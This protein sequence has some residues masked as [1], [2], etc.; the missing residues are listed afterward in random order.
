MSKDAWDL[1]S[2]SL[3]YSINN[4]T[5]WTAFG[6][7]TNTGVLQTLAQRYQI[8]ARQKDRAGNVSDESNVVDFTWDRGTLISHV[9]STSANGVYTHVVGRNQIDITVYFRKDLRIGTGTTPRI[10]INAQRGGNNIDLT[11]PT[12][13]IPGGA[14]NSLTFTYNVQNGDARALPT[15]LDIT[16]ISGITAWD[17]NAVNNGVNVSSLITLPTGTPRLDKQIT[18]ETGNLTRNTITFAADSGTEA[19]ANYHGIRSDDGSYWTT[20]DITFNRSINKGSPTGNIIIQQIAGTGN[21][22]YRL[23]A[24]ITEAQ[25]TRFKSNA[26]TSGIIDNYYIKGTNGYIDGTGS[27]TS[28]KYVLQYNYDTISGV[29]SGSPFAGNTAIPAGDITRFRDAEKIEINVNAS[30]VTVDGS[31]LKIRLTGSNAPQVPGATYTVALPDGLV[32]D[33]L[34]NIYA[35]GNENVVLRG[36]AKPFVRINKTQDTITVNANPS[37]TQPRLVAAQPFLAYAR[38]DCRTPGSTITYNQS[39][40]RT[41]VP[42]RL[43]GTTGDNNNWRYD[44]VTPNANDN[45]TPD[46][47]RPGSATGTNYTNS[48]QVTLGNNA[49]GSIPDITDVQ[50][51]QWWV[52]ARAG[53][54]TTYSLETEEMAYRTVISYQIRNGNGAITAPDGRSIFAAGDQA[55][56]RG[57]DAIGSSSIPGFPFT[58]EDDWGELK[59]KRAGIRLMT[60]VGTNSDTQGMNNSVWRFVTWDMNTTA[61]VDFIRGRDLADGVDYPASSADTAWQYGPKRWCYQVDGWTSFKTF[62]PIYAGKH[63]WCDTGY[64][65]NPPHQAIN[66]SG[67]FMARPSLTASRTPPA[68]ATYTRWPG[69][70]N[71]P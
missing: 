57:G 54:N 40:G 29:T 27:D 55:W 10:T 66:F 69:L 41:N 33:S 12:A 30:V 46:A 35:G 45:A 20:L 2:T 17:G 53:V 70:N 49:N 14:V 6:N 7:I 31:T 47:T 50:G 15:Y 34:G 11:I 32:T 67:T 26:N 56:I 21:T 9:S 18:V 68:T 8:K 44:R 71:A 24:V 22:A 51:Y 63:R 1:T 28:N 60:L 61:Y 43:P 5:S 42:M 59:N 4:G 39:E 23:P 36:V 62:F 38:M 65:F 13:S 37:I 19:N 16:A 58:W 64:Q 52:R 3:E 48:T 25:Y